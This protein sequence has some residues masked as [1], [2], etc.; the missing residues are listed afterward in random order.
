MD[1]WLNRGA[2]LSGSG[3]DDAGAVI[4]EYR[5]ASGQNQVAVASAVPSGSAPSAVAVLTND[6]VL[7]GSPRRIGTYPVAMVTS[8]LR[9]MVASASPGETTT[10]QP[11]MRS[12]LLSVSVFV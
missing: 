4:R 12:P 11:V 10:R 3:E 2:P 5:L 1:A 6:S 8:E 7:P 9:G